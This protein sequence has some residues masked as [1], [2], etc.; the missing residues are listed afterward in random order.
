[1]DKLFG[2]LNV[3]VR[4]SGKLHCSMLQRWQVSATEN[5]EDSDADQYNK[6]LVHTLPILILSSSIKWLNA[7]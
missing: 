1:V 4:E 3:V 7:G 5:A 6:L 2:R